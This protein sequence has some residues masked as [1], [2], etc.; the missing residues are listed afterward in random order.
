MP[1]RINL[2]LYFH[3]KKLTK[4]INC[5]HNISN[6]TMPVY[7]KSYSSYPV[8]FIIQEVILSTQYLNC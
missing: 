4:L 1:E 8:I 7:N 6:S 2:P 3:N 5:I